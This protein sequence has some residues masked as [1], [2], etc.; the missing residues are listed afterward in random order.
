M[1]EEQPL[2]KIVLNVK[3]SMTVTTNKH[4]NFFLKE[5]NKKF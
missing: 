3:E 4:I 2:P 5:Q 1:F